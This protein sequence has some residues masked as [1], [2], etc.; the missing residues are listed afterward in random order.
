MSISDAVFSQMPFL[1]AL[2]LSACNKQMYE[3]IQR[4]MSL[5]IQ[6]DRTTPLIRLTKILNPNN[7]ITLDDVKYTKTY[8]TTCDA[9]IFEN[10]MREDEFLFNKELKEYVIKTFILHSDIDPAQMDLNIVGLFTGCI[11]TFEGAGVPVSRK[12]A[13]FVFMTQIFVEYIIWVITKD[14]QE[15]PA[16]NLFRSYTFTTAY[17]LKVNYFIDNVEKIKNPREE[18][19]ITTYLKSIRKYI[20]AA[21]FHAMALHNPNNKLYIGS[22]GGLYNI[23]N[24]RKNY[25]K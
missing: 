24:G 11:A 17:V 2:T 3:M 20:M 25:F 16:L 6:N 14:Y 12:Y 15:I 13:S 23:R 18:N 4:N 9:V 7:N 10:L 19:D 8:L 21:R 5:I 22:K 1:E